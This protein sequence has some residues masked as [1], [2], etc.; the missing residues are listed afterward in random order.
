MSEP[1]LG[2][3]LA[4]IPVGLL[5]VALGG[6]GL[7]LPGLPATIFFIGAAAAFSRSSPRLESWVLGLHGIGPL[8]RDHRAGLGMPRRAKV[9]ALTMMTAAT[10]FSIVSLGNT[11]LR[12]VLAALWAIGAITIVRTTAR[13]T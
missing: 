5:C 7:A 8:V 11:A 12:I 9:I 2:K 4:W 13:D 10:A 6:L 1:S 3:R